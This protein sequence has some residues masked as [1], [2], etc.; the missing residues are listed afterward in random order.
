MQSAF[1]K[2]AG[3]AF[4]T[5]DMIPSLKEMLS[6]ATNAISEAR[7]TETR[8]ANLPIEARVGPGLPELAQQTMLLLVRLL[9]LR[10]LT[11]LL[12][13]FLDESAQH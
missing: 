6:L 3:C 7:A 11:C 8:I 5:L 1:T 2:A 13:L 10:L 9:Q 4:D 12:G